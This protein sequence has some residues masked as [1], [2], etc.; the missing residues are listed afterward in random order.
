MHW[1]PTRGEGIPDITCAGGTG[2][3]TYTRDASDAEI[4]WT[5]GDPA[6]SNIVGQAVVIHGA[7]D[8]ND[9]IGCGVIAVP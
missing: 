4:A 7:E 2:S 3:L 6:S 1:G 8:N 9:R 5:I